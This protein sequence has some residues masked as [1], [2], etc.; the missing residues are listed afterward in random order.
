[1]SD[2]RIMTAIFRLIDLNQARIITS[3][4]DAVS[5]PSDQDL[6]SHHGDALRRQQAPLADRLRP[7]DLDEFVIREPSLL[8]AGC[9]DAP[10]PPIGSAT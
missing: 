2:G 8:K 7:R 5:G 6:F 10:L 9:S 1:M 3:G 4:F